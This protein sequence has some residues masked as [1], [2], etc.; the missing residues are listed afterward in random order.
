VRTIGFA[1]QSYRVLLCLVAVFVTVGA[2]CQPFPAPPLPPPGVAADVAYLA[3]PALDGRATGTPGSDSAAVYI[4]RQYKSLGL[5]GAFPLTCELPQECRKSY[6]QFFKVDGLSA[7]NIAVM[8]P[9]ADSS[10]RDQYVVAGA[11]YDHLGHSSFGS[12]DPEVGLAIRPGA[13]DNASGSAALLELARR[14]VAHPPRRSVLLVH[15]DAE[16]LGLVGSGVFVDHPPVP[17]Q[18][19]VLM[20]NFDMVGRMQ[21]RTLIVDISPTN[22]GLRSLVDSAAHAVQVRLR[23]SSITAGRTDNTSFRRAKIQT[24][25]LFTGYHYDYHRATDVAARVYVPGIEL[26]VDVAEAVVRAV[27]NKPVGS[28]RR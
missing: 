17:Q 28:A 22:A 10:L 23:F 3:S 11:H 1:R 18:S 27:A 4:A 16:E 6:F 7:Q 13:D 8:I 12:R 5:S 14:L 15:F 2:A 25:S 24:V 20:V 19:I 9:G 21:A 26:A